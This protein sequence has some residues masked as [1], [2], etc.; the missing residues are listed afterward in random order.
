MG[1]GTAV[2]RAGRISDWIHK[3]PTFHRHAK[4]GL[5]VP[6]RRAKRLAILLVG[7][8]LGLLL[9]GTASAK[10]YCTSARPPAQLIPPP[11]PPAEETAE[12][13]ADW[14]AERKHDAMIK[15]G[16]L[17]PDPKERFQVFENFMERPHRYSVSRRNFPGWALFSDIESAREYRDWKNSKLNVGPASFIG[18]DENKLPAPEK[19]E[20]KKKPPKHHGHHEKPEP[21]VTPPVGPPV[22]PAP[23]ADAPAAAPA[24]CCSACNCCPCRCM[25]RCCVRHPVW[26][27]IFHRR[28]GC[29]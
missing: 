2:K 4:R 23:P 10:Q 16:A 1:G 22:T 3:H 11:P 19:M 8:L 26:R 25:R 12:E 24:Q 21:V 13:R 29:R 7:C 28:W 5:I 15:S 14:D 20:A 27:A 18:A 17:K 6:G 9:G